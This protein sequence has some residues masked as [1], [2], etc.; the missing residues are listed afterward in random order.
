MNEKILIVEDE[1]QMLRLLGMTLQKEGYQIAVAQTAAA[2]RS[3]IEAIGPDLL[4]LD[5]MLP[6][7]SGLDLCRELRQ[8]R[9]TSSLPVLM[10]S[11]L[12]QVA[13]KV[14]GLEAGADE[15]VVKPIDS[16]EL[17]ARVGGLLER[18][19]RMRGEGIGKKGKIIAFVACKGGVGTTTA[20]VNVG[21][22]MA[23][24]GKRP[25]AAELRADQGLLSTMLN[26]GSGEGTRGLLALDPE[27][28][29]AR[30]ISGWVLG[31][32]SGLRSLPAVPAIRPDLR[33]EA[34]QALA[35]ASA[36]A[37]LADVVLLDLPPFASA[38][39]EA[40]LGL[41]D[42]ITLTTEPTRLGL[43]A[44]AVMAAYAKSHAR[45]AAE[46]HVL[47]ISRV[48]LAS[49]VAAREFQ[50]RLGWAVLGGVPPAP[51]ECARALQ[52]GGPII[53]VAP[54]STISQAFKHL[55]QAMV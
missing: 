48:A 17:V 47:I 3:Q 42:C 18:A 49:P 40:V 50:E 23:P 14:A 39:A 22:A 26:L 30:S 7:V 21:A 53:Q 54:E 55:A 4:I 20:A 1:P 36:L 28:I 27:Q 43:E 51:D 13:D 16:L 5:V 52:L 11:A 32:S 15:Y 45:P 9:T 24:L 29:D 33:L 8:Q 38:A 31:H 46:L 6:D 37:G 12:G 2:A 44:A 10:L 34:K 41:S 19:A 35:I 25:I